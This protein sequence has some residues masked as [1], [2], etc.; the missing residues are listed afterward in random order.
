M[1]IYHLFL[2]YPTYNLCRDTIQLL[3]LLDTVSA[4]S[5]LLQ[6]T[7]HK[8]REIG[9]NGSTACKKMH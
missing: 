1:D 5:K 3:L 6:L 4:Q 9:K 2:V 7:A 8:K